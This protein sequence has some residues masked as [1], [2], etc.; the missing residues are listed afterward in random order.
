MAED[1]WGDLPTGDTMRTPH[2]VML[3][4][5]NL[6]TKKT[7]GMLVSDVARGTQSD[8]FINQLFIMAPSL[9]NYRYNVISVSHDV[10]L[11]PARIFSAPFP[12]RTVEDEEELKVALRE[13]FT[14]SEVRKVIS[15]LLAQIR[16]EGTST[17]TPT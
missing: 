15:A 16:S 6:L 17:E 7:S 12:N 3:E 14:A 9:N 11:Y 13:A 1:L 5:A 8:R 2:A 4:Q 10:T